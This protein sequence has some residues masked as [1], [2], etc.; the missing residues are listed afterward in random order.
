M[1]KNA[2]I[3]GAT[4]ATGK[5][6]LRLLLENNNYDKVY[7]VHRK[8]GKFGETE[9]LKEIVTDFSKLETVLESINDVDDVFCCIGSTI[10]KAGSATQ[11]HI[12]DCEYP[13]KL[14]NWAEKKKARS[15]HIVSFSGADP[16]A[17]NYYAR[18]KGLMEKG[19]KSLYLESVYIY[20]PLLL[21]RQSGDFR[22]GEFAAIILM[23]I[24]HPFLL[25]PLK[26]L[27]PLQTE[28]LAGVM[29]RKAQENKKGFY[30]L[31]PEELLKN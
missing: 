23:T 16:E 22:L 27:R 25:G 7:A 28:K 8:H 4:G 13:L 11:F 20:K 3:T 14:G 24:F 2:L 19:L 29:F 9:K 15:F 10:K 26:K 5:E 18:T 6:L 17:L 31:G 30:N 1:G 21:K 12:I